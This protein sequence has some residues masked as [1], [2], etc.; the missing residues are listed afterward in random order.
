VGLVD[1]AG[2]A[3]GDADTG[4]ECA[5]RVFARRPGEPVAAG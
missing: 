1:I 5:E 2:L 4:R 3:L